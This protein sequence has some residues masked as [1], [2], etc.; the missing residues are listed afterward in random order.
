MGQ[1]RKALGEGWPQRWSVR[2]GTLP[3]FAQDP[4]SDAFAFAQLLETGLRL[5]SLAGTLRLRSVVRQWSSHVEVIGMRHAWIQLEVA[6]LARFL[7]A[8]AEFETPFR[9]SGAERPADV[10]I[11]V[12]DA[13]K[14][15]AECFSIYSDQNT[16][17]SMAY[18]QDFGFRLSMIALDVR[19][20]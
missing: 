2:L 9:L 15:I 19:A 6:A 5:H 11:T 18:D 3:A 4:A 20:L 8:A 16:R 17:E 12:E 1:V 13:G 10:V 14:I 7:G